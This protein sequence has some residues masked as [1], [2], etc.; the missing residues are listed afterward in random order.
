MNYFHQELEL[1]KSTYSGYAGNSFTYLVFKQLTKLFLNEVY[2]YNYQNNIFTYKELIDYF[3]LNINNH[4]EPFTIK[5]IPELLESGDIQK[6]KYQCIKILEPCDINNFPIAHLKI[7]LI[8]T[9][10][11]T[12]FLESYNS[13]IEKSFSDFWDYDQVDLNS[14]F[15]DN[16]NETTV[17][18]N[19]LKDLLLKKIWEGEGY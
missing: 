11:T 12:N 5:S 3:N 6:V 15:M 16:L 1:Y 10:K 4:P 8:D 17:F 18:K 9:N 13:L 7:F 14:E 2:L 19:K